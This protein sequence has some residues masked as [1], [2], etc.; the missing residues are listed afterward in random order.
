MVVSKL[1]EVLGI[2][3]NFI[4]SIVFYLN[5]VKIKRLKVKKEIFEKYGVVS[6][7]VVREMFVGLKI[8]IGILIIGIVG[9]GGGIKDKLVGFV[10]IGIKVK[11]EVKVFKRELK[12]DRNKIR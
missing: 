7:E 10:Y 9:L 11:N 8:D 3:E 2:L 12:G 1:I 5:E 4:E 6:E